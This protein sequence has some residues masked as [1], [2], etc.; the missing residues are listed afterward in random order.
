MIKATKSRFEKRKIN[1]T[2]PQELEKKGFF[3]KYA[4]IKSIKKPYL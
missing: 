1:S 4:V 3:K 2:D